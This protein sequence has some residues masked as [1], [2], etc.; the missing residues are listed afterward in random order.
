MKSAYGDWYDPRL[1]ALV[2]AYV[3]HRAAMENNF[4]ELL[5]WDMVEHHTTSFEERS[6]VFKELSHAA[7][8]AGD[9][10]FFRQIDEVMKAVAAGEEVEDERARGILHAYW[11][12][13]FVSGKGYVDPPTIQEVVD[14]TDRDEAWGIGPDP[15]QKRGTVRDF[16]ER[17]G[18]RWTNATAQKGKKKRG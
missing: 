11:K 5:R 12:L 8:L 16:L 17:R 18:L 7:L 1:V 10:E 2:R 9:N 13:S 6:T 14:Q 3:Y 15:K 4:D